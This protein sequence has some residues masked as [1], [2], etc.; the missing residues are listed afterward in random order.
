MAGV[1]NLDE[2]KEKVVDLID[3]MGFSADLFRF[4]MSSRLKQDS[5]D[6]VVADIK[7]ARQAMFE[8]IDSGELSRL[9]EPFNN[10][11]SLIHI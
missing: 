1:E 2:L 3:E 4:G 5:N 6:S 10:D 11:L 9:V 7:R 8:K